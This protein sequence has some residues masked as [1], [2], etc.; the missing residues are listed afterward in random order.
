MGVALPD[1]VG[2]LHCLVAV[3]TALAERDRTGRGG[4]VDISQL[5]TYAAIGGETYLAASE[6]GAAPPRRG[7][8]SPERAP[9]GVYRC[10]G[11]D[12]WVAIS[13]ESEAEWQALARLVGG[14]LDATHYR[15]LAG[16]IERHD[17]I[18]RTIASWSAA[19]DKREAMRTLQAA[20][21]RAG[22]VMTN[23]DIVEDEHIASRG[24]MV[25]WDQPDVGRR[26][27]PGFPIHF[28]DP[29]EIPMRGTPL[30]GAD[31]HYVL[32][33]VLGY[34]EESV[35]ALAEAGVIATE[36]PQS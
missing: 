18:D 5:E 20:G 25:E 24:F 12:E 19:R 30:L 16:R 17:E 34:P 14:G 22:A 35:A 21:V 31:N 1:P 6:T 36:P 29:G 8:R 15:T 9:Q 13:V 26:R 4:F 32:T 33:E 28:T 3:L 10:A 7:N 23:R 2:G 11:D 27:F